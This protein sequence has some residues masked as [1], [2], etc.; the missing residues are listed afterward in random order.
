MAVGRVTEPPV[1]I[2]SKA[3]SNQAGIP[4]LLPNVNAESATAA[5]PHF[6]LHQFLI[7]QRIAISI[8]QTQA[9]SPR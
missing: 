7:V 8:N 4:D 9:L 2:P 5:F 6:Q 3:L 1:D